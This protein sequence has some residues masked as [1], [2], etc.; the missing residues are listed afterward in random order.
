MH[1]QY[2]LAALEQAQLGAGQC[3]PNPSV[4]AVA[5]QNGKIIAQ[6]Y[7]QGAGTPHAEQLLLAQLPPKLPALSVYITLE[8]CT[9][10][11]K[12]PPCVDALIEY[13]VEHVYFAHFDPNPIVA[14]NGSIQK[15]SAHGITVAHIPIQAINQFYTSYTYWL[16]T[17]KPWVT[18]KIAQTFDG[19]I[20]RVTGD[21]VLLSN[22]LCHEFTHKRRLASD[23][24]LT[25]ARTIRF[26]N[27][28]LNVRLSNQGIAKPVAIIDTHLELD[29]TPQIFSTSSHCHIYYDENLPFPNN[30]R[31][32][33]NYYPMPT[34]EGRMDLDAVITHLGSLG[35]H[36]VWVEVGA[37]LFNSLHQQRL[38]NRTYV[39]LVPRLLGAE[40][41]SAYPDPQLFA[42]KHKISW[43]EMDDNMVVCFDWQEEPCLQ[44]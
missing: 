28:K 10:W 21:R 35:Y 37:T 18:I 2:L 43:R 16:R 40:G 5:V 39:Y 8:P 36:D 14:Q 33:V 29:L 20:G 17:Q 42:A 44:A 7:H 24:L 41:L 27:P 31:D 15:L 12:T 4:G 22:A 9:H 23:V 1:E 19:K 13:G 26:D 3:A 6:A 25:S 38:V 30:N 32:N 11:G 34:H